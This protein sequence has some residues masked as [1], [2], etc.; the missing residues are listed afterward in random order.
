[1]LLGGCLPLA[2]CAAPAVPPAASSVP[3]IAAPSAPPSFVRPTPTPLPT[4]LEYVVHSGDSLSSIARRFATT[5]RSIALWN[6]ARY[7]TL[8]PASA[9]YAPDRIG[10]GWRL[11]LVPGMTF[12]EAADASAGPT[13]SAPAPPSPSIPPGP[14]ERPDGVAVFVAHASRTTSAVALTLDLTRK[15]VPPAAVDAAL[16]ALASRGAPATVFASAALLAA[17]D[18]G[19]TELVARSGP[20][21]ILG[22]ASGSGA[23]SADALTAA[24]SAASASGVS[25][26]PWYRPATNEPDPAELATAGRA[27]WAYAIG[28]DVDATAALTGPDLVAFAVSRSGLGSIIRLDLA[29]SDVAAALPD[30]LDGLAAHGLVPVTIPV[31]LGR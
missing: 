6:A 2:G 9:R 12:E 22:V 28:W 20:S 23:T 25:T 16:D 17:G 7:P 29:D 19:A 5:A 1:M 27:G 10:V 13:P 31:L 21:V 4:P 3:P 11:I 26:R 15:G 24:E 30:L 18:P 8:D 14:T